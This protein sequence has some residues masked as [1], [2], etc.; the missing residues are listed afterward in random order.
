MIFT[1]TP[2]NYQDSRTLHRRL[3]DSSASPLLHTD[4]LIIW[5]ERTGGKPRKR[6]SGQEGEGDRKLQIQFSARKNHGQCRRP[7]LTIDLAKVKSR[8]SWRVSKPCCYKLPLLSNQYGGQGFSA[9]QSPDSQAVRRHYFRSEASLARIKLQPRRQV[10]SSSQVCRKSTQLE[11]VQQACRKHGLRLRALGPWG[12]LT[13]RKHT[14]K[15][16]A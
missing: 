11:R 6:E 12:S 8:D 4:Q 16:L 3:G 13:S 14:L 1:L 5:K 7:L 15:S 9:A 10:G 2:Q